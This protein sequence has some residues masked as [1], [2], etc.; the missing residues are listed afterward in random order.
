[1]GQQ[2]E[3]H[4]APKTFNLRV[5]DRTL[6][7]PLSGLERLADEIDRSADALVMPCH[8]VDALEGFFSAISKYGWRLDRAE[9]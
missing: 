3:V 4:T 5:G 9:T 8:C 6:A 2:A 1:M 7:L